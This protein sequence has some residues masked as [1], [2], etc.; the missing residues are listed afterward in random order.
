MIHLLLIS[1]VLGFGD[2]PVVDNPLLKE[3]VTK[4][5]VLPHR[6]VPLPAPVMGDGLSAAEQAAVIKKL[7][8]NYQLFIRNKDVSPFVLK[9]DALEGANKERIGQKVDLYFVAYGPL[10]SAVSS[11][12]ME[13][14]LGN[15]KA[16]I[17]K[18][19]AALLSE[20]DLK[21]RNIA[22]AK[23]KGLEERYT[24]MNFELLD[25][26]QLSG[27]GRAFKTNGPNAIVSAMQLDPRFAEDKQ[28]PNQWQ[29]VS[30]KDGVKVL[31]PAKSYEG[32]GGYVR[33]TELKEPAGALFVEFHLVLNEP[34]EW[35][36]GR[37]LI[38]AKLRL[39][40]EER[41]RSF[42]RQLAAADKKT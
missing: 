32:F 42:R 24:L 13:R 16:N 7:T 38:K 21:K 2:A 10:Q 39:A 11:D 1:S 4:G 8:P 33:M 6:P 26:V 25:K 5:L 31:G 30:S 27:V 19:K 14:L 9:I 36:G 40:I 37:N 35:F 41:V 34:K 28:F 20:D 29:P 18:G 12:V 22:L 15:P 17:G 23:S 3:L